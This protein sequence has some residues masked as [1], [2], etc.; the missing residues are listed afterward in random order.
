MERIEETVETV[1]EP[2]AQNGGGG[3]YTRKMSL[4][5]ASASTQQRR[6]SPIPP[7]RGHVERSSDCRISDVCWRIF[8]VRLDNCKLLQMMKLQ[9]K[10]ELDLVLDS[11]FGYRNR[12]I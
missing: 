6:L 10:K 3:G 11:H 4:E 2:P 8:N 5:L 9:D 1:L 7:Y 12:T